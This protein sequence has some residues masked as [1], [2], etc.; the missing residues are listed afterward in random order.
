L[1]FFRA[2]SFEVYFTLVTPSTSFSSFVMVC[3][4]SPDTWS[5]IYKTM[6]IFSLKLCNEDSVIKFTNKIMLKIKRMIPITNIVAID[7]N[8]FR[9]MFERLKRI[10]LLSRM[11]FDS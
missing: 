11:R 3:D 5:S 9:T 8:L 4:W 1:S 6:S 10:A 7:R 2:C